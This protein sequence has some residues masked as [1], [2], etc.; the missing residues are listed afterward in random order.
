M[1][2]LIKQDVET[3]HNL[4]QYNAGRIP[5]FSTTIFFLLPYLYIQNVSPTT[6]FS[7]KLETRPDYEI[8][9][10]SLR[11]THT[12]HTANLEWLRVPV[13]IN[14]ITITSN[15]HKSSHK[16]CKGAQC[17]GTQ[18]RQR[19]PVQYSSSYS[20]TRQFS[21]WFS[22]YLPSFVCESFLQ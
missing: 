12:A 6:H 13:P 18:T 17:A 4:F 7:Y 1:S 8:I 10:S 15:V 21:H 16:T 2:E 3:R 22:L 14:F 19:L 11:H 9:I 5:R 20:H